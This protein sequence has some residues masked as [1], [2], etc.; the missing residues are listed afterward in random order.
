MKTIKNYLFLIL[1][2]SSVQVTAT[3]KK[4]EK[5]KTLIAQFDQSHSLYKSTPNPILGEKNFHDKLGA[6]SNSYKSVKDAARKLAP[7]LLHHWMFLPDGSPQTKEAATKVKKVLLLLKS[8]KDNIARF[9]W[10]TLVDQKLTTKKS[11]LLVDLLKP[12]RTVRFNDACALNGLPT[13]AYG[14]DIQAAYALALLRNQQTKQFLA[15]IKVLKTKVSVNYKSGPDFGLDYGPEAGKY[16]YR[17]TLNYIQLCDVI[18][19]YHLALLGKFTGAK[20]W[21]QKV[22]KMDG[23]P[24]LETKYIIDEINRIIETKK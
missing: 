21:A 9:T 19:G 3:D 10:K 12:N 20:S 4:Q 1:L 6:W 11:A 5:L 22:V 13:E 2:L 14:W 23:A 16:R 18:N 17:T 24:S 15:E 8:G 7:E